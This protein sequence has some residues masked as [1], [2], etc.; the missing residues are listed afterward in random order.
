[1]DNVDEDESGCVLHKNKS[2]Q[3]HHFGKSYDIHK[4][5]YSQHYPD[6]KFEN[7]FV[8]MEC[9][10]NKCVQISH[11]SYDNTITKESI[12]KR[13]TKG[14]QMIEDCLVYVKDGRGIINIGGNK[15]FLH[16]VVY[17][18]HSD[19]ETLEDLPDTKKTG[20]VV[21]HKC[22]NLLCL[23]GNHFEIGTHQDNTRD[24]R[25]TVPKSQEL[26]IQRG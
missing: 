3:I 22:R 17:W 9:G 16:R 20:L 23:N 6:H 13:I 11:M 19:L 10:K 2:N 15:Y 24:R 7:N 26:Y 21:R 25:E 1:M 5:V 14:A 4:S 18:I 8:I 12:L